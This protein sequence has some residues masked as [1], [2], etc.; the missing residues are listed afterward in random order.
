M[1]DNFEKY[2]ADFKQLPLKEKQMLIY[3]QLKMLAG[4]TNSFCKEINADNEIIIDKELSDLTKED[5]TEDDFAEAVV[6]LVNS[7][8]NSIC[9][10]HLKMSEII[11]DKI[12]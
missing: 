11:E 5:Y 2:M 12:S 8:Q 4:L 9:D 7:I 6:V 3:D 10:F 1:E